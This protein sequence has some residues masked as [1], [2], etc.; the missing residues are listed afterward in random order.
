MFRAG[1]RREETEMRMSETIPGNGEEI[2]VKEVERTNPA[3]SRCYTVEDLQIMLGISRASV[4]ALLK[5]GE[6]RSFQIGGRY[7]ISKKSFDE[8]LDCLA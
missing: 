7:R 8:W 6:F 3:E 4:Y 5:R 2:R 1:D